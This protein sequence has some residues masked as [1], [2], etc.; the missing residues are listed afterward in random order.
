MFLERDSNRFPPAAPRPFITGTL[1]SFAD[2]RAGTLAAKIAKVHPAAQLFGC[3]FLSSRHF[4]VIEPVKFREE[5]TGGV[6]EEAADVAIGAGVQDLTG[7]FFRM[8]LFYSRGFFRLY[9]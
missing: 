4:P 2:I 6:H 5:K 7:G 9:P 1:I 8:V 3:Y